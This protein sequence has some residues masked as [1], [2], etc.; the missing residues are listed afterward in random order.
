MQ[1]LPLGIGAWGGFVCILVA[2]NSL[3]HDLDDQAV[4]F[5]AGGVALLLWTVWAGGVRPPRR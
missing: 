1:R 4:L 2:A 3:A 5:L